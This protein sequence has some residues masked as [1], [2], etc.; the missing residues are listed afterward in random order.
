M[1]SAKTRRGLAILV[2]LIFASA[3]MIYVK[4]SHR[5]EVSSPHLSANFPAPLPIPQPP[6]PS[7]H[8]PIYAHSIVNGGVRS[9]EELLEVLRTDP[10]VAAHYKNINLAK[11]HI[12]T[13]D[14]PLFAYVSYRI[15]GKGIYWTMRPVSIPAQES[16]LTDGRTYIRTRCGN[17]IAATPKAPTNKLSEPSDLDTV[18][19]SS[20][21][22]I[23][24]TGAPDELSGV[25][26]D[27]PPTSEDIVPDSPLNAATPS[28]TTR[29]LSPASL[30]PP[31]GGGICPGC[32][33][34]S[35][36]P[37]QPNSPAT[38]IPEPDS[39]VLLVVGIA[40]IPLLKVW[41]K[42]KARTPRR[43]P[44]RNFHHGL[45][46]RPIKYTDHS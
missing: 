17:V 6:D 45:S 12:V 19:V 37:T 31:G 5:G 21:P 32:P 27:P 1:N 25:S 33:I 14:H 16:L 20:P 10:E 9:V 43:T 7:H 22:P 2:A 46:A 28:P 24:E 23:Q 38:T 29:S 4:S 39:L 42:R 40:G 34:V 8:N 11:A 3:G 15:D 26:M 36:F 44:I 41:T 35:P 18:V 13:L 30:A